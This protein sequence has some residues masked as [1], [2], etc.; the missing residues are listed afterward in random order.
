MNLRI[1]PDCL[2]EVRG[3]E[4]YAGNKRKHAGKQY[5]IDHELG[6]LWIRP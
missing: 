5:D 3:G 6:H 1:D 4:H 2:E